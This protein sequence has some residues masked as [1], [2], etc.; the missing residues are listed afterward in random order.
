MPAL[1]RIFRDHG[2][3]NG[4]TLSVFVRDCV[5]ANCFPIDSRVANELK[6]YG[7]PEDEQ[8]LVNLCLN[9]G[10][11]PREVARV[12]F[13]APQPSAGIVC[14]NSGHDQNRSAPSA[15]WPGAGSIVRA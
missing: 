14:R 10:L 9:A 13:Q 2:T 6:T 3:R 15:A 7:I 1:D 12:F 5:K 8:L 11:N 4:K